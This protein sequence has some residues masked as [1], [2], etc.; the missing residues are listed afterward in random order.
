MVIVNGKI[1]KN[2]ITVLSVSS[3]DENVYHVGHVPLSQIL[4]GSTIR[5]IIDWICSLNYG[6]ESSIVIHSQK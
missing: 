4:L 6:W 2:T 5:G 3:L 1:L